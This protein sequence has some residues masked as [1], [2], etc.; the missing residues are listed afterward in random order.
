MRRSGGRLKPK[1]LRQ[2]QLARNVLSSSRGYANRKL[3]LTEHGVHE[4]DDLSKTV[5]RSRERPHIGRYVLAEAIGSG[6]AGTVYRA[7][8]DLLG[9]EVAVKMLHR[10]HMEDDVL[11]GRFTQEA[12][13]AASV[14]G[15]HVVD[16]FDCGITDRGEVYIVMEFLRGTTLHEHLCAYRPLP[17]IE[18]TDITTQI[19]N[20]LETLHA[21]N[22]VHRDLKPANVFL[23]RA[24]SSGVWVKLLD[25]GV[26]KVERAAPRFTAPRTLVGTPSYMAPE[27][28]MGAAL[29]D[30]R[31]DLYSVGVILYEMLSGGVPF[32]GKTYAEIATKALTLEPPP[33]RS[34]GLPLPVARVVDIAV[35]RDPRARWQNATDFRTS[36]IDAVERADPTASTRVSPH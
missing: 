6:A 27:Q 34:H 7:F 14:G 10:K 17:L 25:F 21:Y 36:L 26:G 30:C 33:L 23:T 24:G 15:P 20:G 22:V 12:R 9:R 28:H 35:A 19:L 1:G 8:D 16:T 13:I 11:V 31:A 5:P 4:V 29:V 18:A 2:L 32:D 3:P